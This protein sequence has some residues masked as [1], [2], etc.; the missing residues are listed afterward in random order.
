MTAA[1]VLQI[2][3]SARAA[4]MGSAYTGVA[5]DAA[6]LEYNPAGLSGLQSHE[7]SLTHMKGFVDQTIEHAAFGLPL[8]F[9]G[10]IGNGYSSLG[11]GVTMSRFGDIEVN[12]TRPDGSFLD[13]RTLKAGGDL[14]ASFGYAER[15]AETPVETRKE[16]YRV[17]HFIGV[18]GK[19]VRSTLAQDHSAAAYAADWG[20]LVMITA[21]GFSLGLSALPLG[22]KMRFIEEA[23]PLPMTF[24]GGVGYL[25]PLDMIESPPSQALLLAADGDYLYF[26]KQWHVNL[27]VEYSAMRNYFV[28]LGYQIHRDIAGLTVGFGAR[29][30]GF[31]VDYA[32]AL[33]EAMGDLHR[34][35]LSWRFGKV[36]VRTREEQRRPFIES[37][38]EQEGLKE[39]EEKTPEDIPFKP[40]RPS[41]EKR[42]PSAPGWIY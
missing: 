36:E 13:T 41:P 1:P 39:L 27:G 31:G 5:A 4:A 18:G 34:V 42:R 7:F 20:S 3:L 12:R 33:T 37:M 16:N 2:P 26:E 28:R 29:W 6:A 21:A 32:W 40:R 8:P 14:V 24:K 30:R 19:W 38:P 25:L 17:D 22:G 10:L 35:G 9:A 11:L 23:D 15:L